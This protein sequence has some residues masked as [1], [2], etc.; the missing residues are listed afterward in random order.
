L[1]PIVRS[2]ISVSANNEIII[3]PALFLEFRA[4]LF[5]L[6][7]LLFEIFDSGSSKGLW[8]KRR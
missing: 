1:S 5:E 4:M 3:I 2:L 8:Q 6:G 7:S